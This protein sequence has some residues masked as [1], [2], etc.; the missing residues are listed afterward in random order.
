MGCP[1][2]R[3]QRNLLSEARN[4]MTRRETSL[5]TMGGP[6]GSCPNK[7][8]YKC[9]MARPWRPSLLTGIHMRSG[10]IIKNRSL[11]TLHPNQATPAALNALPFACRA[12]G[13]RR[14][15]LVAACCSVLGAA[16]KGPCLLPPLIYLRVRLLDLQA[17]DCT[18]IYR[19][20]LALR[21]CLVERLDMILL[22]YITVLVSG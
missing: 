10:T 20:T 22:L 11:Y 9:M 13:P 6:T 16:A 18:R 12:P 17:Y 1:K 5:N 15:S 8:I 7:G 19:F 2:R 4:P 14:V 3:N 21:V